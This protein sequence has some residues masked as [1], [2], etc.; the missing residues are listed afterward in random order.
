MGTSAPFDR[1]DRGAHLRCP[2][3]GSTAP[4]DH[5]G[6]CPTC[7][8]I[9]ECVYPDEALR[10][11]RE[12]SSAKGMDRYLPLLPVARP[13]PTLGEGDTP[14]LPSR[15]V[16]ARLGLSQLFLKNET[17][18]P[19]GSFKDRGATIAIARA[20]SKGAGGILTASTGNAAA[21]L[22]GYSAA[23]GLPCLVLFSA[24]SPASKLR[25]ALAYG[26]RCL[27]VEGLFD[28]KPEHFIHLLISVSQRLE[29]ELAFFWAPISPCP[30]EGM[31]TIA[32]EVVSQMGGQVPDVVVC[33]V[34]G[35]DG[36]VGQ[37]RGY[38][39]LLRAGA[40]DHLPRMI[41]VQPSG[42]A[43]MVSSF[44]RGLD[45]V[46]PIPEANT[47]ASGLR[48]TFSGEHALRAIRDSSGTAIAVDDE[49]NLEAQRQ[50]ARTE[51]VWVEPSG[52]ITVAA[53]PALSE[54][55][56]IARDERVVCVLTGAGFKDRQHDGVAEETP[57]LMA[58][59]VSFDLDDVVGRA[60]AMLRAL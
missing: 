31:K 26:A 36:L 40:I 25:Q 15:N 47:V 23:Q 56:A 42:A 52:S 21:A 54:A 37:W 20:L 39:E 34:G 13:L 14:L 9:L 45:R 27:Q 7:A 50:L 16:G 19:T 4:L 11:L 46:A 51:G 38:N 60:R 33:P 43:P 57:D 41:G 49:R 53:L 55:G 3:C 18:S 12:V 35:G 5:L 2:A 1:G 10:C 59:A 58:P 17:V 32:Y 8:G 30:M 24:G 28:G 48:V 6:L 22:S 44:H 29:L